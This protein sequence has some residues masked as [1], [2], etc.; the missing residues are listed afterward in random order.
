MKVDNKLETEPM[1]TYRFPLAV[2]LAGAMGLAGCGVELLTTTAIEADLQAQQAAAMK[3]QVKNAASTTGRI[4]IERA[5]QTYIAEKGENPPSLDALVPDFLPALPK[6]A[7]GSDYAYDPAAGKLKDGPSASLRGIP[8]ADRQMMQDIRAA[9][10][11]YGTAVGYYPPTLDA[12][13]PD[14]L[15][16]M[17]R[18]E[19]GEAFVYDNQDG[20]LAHPREE[21]SQT[22]AAPRAQAGGGAGGAGPM[23]EVMTG[24]GMQNQLNQMNQSGV[25]SA[26]S[27]M[28]ESAGGLAQ[29]QDARNN[30]AMDQLGL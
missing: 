15:A 4:N 17:P 8:A 21:Q 20:Y 7:D 9:I 6:Q 19:T 22:A 16:K 29:G 5:I 3:N 13:Y 11:S 1:T 23:G 2:L 26:G 18:T 24:I 27:R 10:N 14:Y 28:R 25:S 30:Q 12:L